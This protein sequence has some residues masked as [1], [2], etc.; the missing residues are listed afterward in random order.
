MPTK[1]LMAE[2]LEE[3]VRSSLRKADDVYVAV[4]WATAS[5]PLHKRLLRSGD[6]VRSLVVGLHFH[7]TDPRFIKAWRD[8]EDS[9][10]R[11]VKD[12]AG[13]FHPKVYLFRSG[14]R[15]T[16][17]V[18][19]ANF[20]KAGFSDNTEAAL[21]VT[22]DWGAPLFTDLLALVE[23]DREFVEPTDAWL[24]KYTLGWRRRK[25]ARKVLANEDED[26][27][28]E[29]VSHKLAV[30]FRTYAD[31]I[32]NAGEDRAALAA[33]NHDYVTWLRVLDGIRALPGWPSVRELDEEGWKVVLG[34]RQYPG[35]DRS[36][37]YRHFGWVRG[38]RKR[39]AASDKARLSI[40]RI[41]PSGPVT[42][43]DWTRF[44]NDYQDALSETT[45]P[46]ASRL[47][48]L[49]RPDRFLVANT[50]SL[51]QLEVAVGARPRTLSD[52]W[53]LHQVIWSWPWARAP[54]PKGKKLRR[55]WDARV[56]LLDVLFYDPT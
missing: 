52:Y 43:R 44:V 35:G 4:A 25:S 15:G 27:P 48:A 13:V 46:T 16:A 45:L 50:R 21:R 14:D 28:L 38:A 9:P 7:Q 6:K 20:T 39:L 34:V 31:L 10:L 53:E 37:D 22:G 29:T 56:A 1:L 36:V 51:E 8:L 32:K 2:D 3:A 47:L 26:L 30:D 49:R 5:N 18:G 40:E 11:L 12:T 42:R 33:R 19:S 55:I 17:I 23:V 41:P 54:R 24:E